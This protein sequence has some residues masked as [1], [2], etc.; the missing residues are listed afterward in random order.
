MFSSNTIHKDRCLG[1]DGHSSE[2]YV[3]D[4]FTNLTN[5]YVLNHHKHALVL[6][7]KKQKEQI[8]GFSAYFDGTMVYGKDEKSSKKLRNSI[9]AS[10][11]IIF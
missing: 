7:L 4:Y 8:N 9:C 2:K 3:E 11:A 5:S 1:A 6:R 10:K